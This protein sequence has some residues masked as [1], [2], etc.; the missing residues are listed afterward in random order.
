MTINLIC[1]LEEKNQY[2]ILNQ[3]FSGLV[4]QARFGLAPS[5]SCMGSIFFLVA[6]M[7]QPCLSQRTTFYFDI[8]G[9]SVDLCI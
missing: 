9:F 7:G 3:F 4:V 6:L 2:P 8:G 1:I 5:D